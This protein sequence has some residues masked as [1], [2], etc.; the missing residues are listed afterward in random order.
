MKRFTFDITGHSFQIEVKREDE[1][2]FSVTVNKN[3][4]SGTIEDRRDNTM[5]LAVEGGLFT[6]ELEKERGKESFHATVNGRGR[7]IGTGIMR[8][9]GTREPAHNACTEAVTDTG[10]KSPGPKVVGGILAPMP[11]KVV[12]VNVIEGDVVKTGDVVLILEAM[13]MEN[14][15]CANREGRVTEVRVSEGDSVDSNDVMVVIE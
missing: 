10:K 7:N 4:F 3:K 5:L 8:E 6:I 12:K 14:E 11:G 2:H 13:K 9:V 1:R 15:I